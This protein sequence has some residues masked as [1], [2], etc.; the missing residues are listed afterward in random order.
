M[1]A[2]FTAIPL[3]LILF[4]SLAL[5]DGGF[6][7]FEDI[8][9]NESAQNAIVAWDGTTEVFILSVDVS[10]EISSLAFYIIPLPAD[11]EKVEPVEFEIFEDLANKF[12][13]KKRV[14][15]RSE[16]FP[17]ILTLGGMAGGAHGIEITFLQVFD[18]HNIM[19]VKVND[20]NYFLNWIGNY[21][22]RI[23]KDTPM[24][25]EQFKQT[26]TDYVN[27]GKNYFVFDIITIGSDAQ[28]VKPILFKF[29]SDELY[30]PVV[31]TATSA[32]SDEISEINLFL[33]SKGM[34]DPNTVNFYGEDVTGDYM[35]YDILA[36]HAPEEAV[37]EHYDSDSVY[38]MDGFFDDDQSRQTNFFSAAIKFTNA[39][40]QEI[41]PELAS[42]F[43]DE[44]YVANTIY[45]GDLT[46]LSEDIAIKSSDLLEPTED[47]KFARLLDES[48]GAFLSSLALMVL[49]L[50]LFCLM[51]TIIFPPAFLV[52]V[53]CVFFFYGLYAIAVR[54][55]KKLVEKFK[56]S[57]KKAKALSYLLVVIIA[58]F[59]TALSPS[60]AIGLFTV[61]A[62][63]GLI[64]LIIY[65]HKKK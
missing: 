38:V 44:A 54:L 35:I 26:V 4:S 63:Y 32:V 52:S 22:K 37:Y 27:A 31:I 18:E 12:N 20:L 59:P 39:E 25:P 53:M 7:P 56:F 17:G 55:P 1:K 9:V 5:A 64:E 57:S 30:F 28:S 49:I 13:E 48:A 45:L 51:M 11:P 3:L 34:I 10:T 46:M 19:V 21:A 24:V 60:V 33:F 8:T 15:E 65:F 23:N 61:V 43:E 40:L 62:I 16:V 36:G 6:I 41:N 29:P 58:L 50:L 2:N 47:E 14:T 42:L